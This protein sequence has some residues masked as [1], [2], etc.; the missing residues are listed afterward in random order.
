[1]WTYHPDLLARPVPRYTSYPTAPEFGDAV[2]QGTMASAL[3]GVPAD[4]PISLYLN[5]PYCHAI[6]WYGGCNTGAANR[7]ARLGAY[8]TRLHQEIALVAERPVGRGRVERSAMVAT[9]LDSHRAE[10]AARF[11]HA[12]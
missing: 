4:A 8:L 2:C 10:N 3:S 11:S 6:C 7:T 9:T 1:M 5:I 12:I